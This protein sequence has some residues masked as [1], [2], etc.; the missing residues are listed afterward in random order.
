M[1][2]NSNQI[3][4]WQEKV[5]KQPIVWCVSDREGNISEIYDTEEAAQVHVA[6]DKGKYRSHPMHIHNL[7]LAQ[8]RFNK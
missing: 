4:E 8:E 1:F 6:S 3:M 7:E 5:K 2:M